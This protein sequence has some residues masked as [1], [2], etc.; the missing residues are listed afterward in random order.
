[1]HRSVHRLHHFVSELAYSF[2]Y[3]YTRCI[4]VY[5]RLSHS[6]VQ[7]TV[8]LLSQF[9]FMISF[10]KFKSFKEGGLY[11]VDYDK[12]ASKRTE[13][14]PILRSKSPFSLSPSLPISCAPDD[15]NGSG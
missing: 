4:C 10:L 5:V 12:L 14:L 15:V 7:D 9:A 3:I 2:F 11:I 6:L 13:G 1:M 8:I